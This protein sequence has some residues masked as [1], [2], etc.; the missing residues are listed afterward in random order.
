[1]QKKARDTLR[2]VDWRRIA[3][4]IAQSRFAVH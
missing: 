4:G 1:M 3:D 2:R